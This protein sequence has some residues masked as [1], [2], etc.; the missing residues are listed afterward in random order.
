MGT[1]KKSIKIAMVF[2]IGAFLTIIY[3]FRVFSLVFLGEAKGP[4]GVK[5]DSRGMVMS[6]A[7][8]ALLS[9]L[10]GIFINYPAGIVQTIV[11]NMP[12]IIR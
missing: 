7:L 4:T 9:I 8:L 12:G 2:L 10:F 6:V 5:E 3:L 11:M 1:E